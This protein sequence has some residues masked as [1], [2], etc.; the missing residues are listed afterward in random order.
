MNGIQWVDP[1]RFGFVIGGL[2]IAAGVGMLVRAIRRRRYRRLV[3]EVGPVCAA[4]GVPKGKWHP[5]TG[6]PRPDSRYRGFAVGRASVV[7][8]QRDG[9]R[10]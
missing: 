6:E 9:R 1:G 7:P 8:Q 2:L 10:G 5:S 4:Y 3:A